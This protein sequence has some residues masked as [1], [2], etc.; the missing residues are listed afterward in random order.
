MPRDTRPG[1]RSK[2]SLLRLNRRWTAYP[3]DDENL[4]SL[5]T[6]AA[7]MTVSL[8]SFLYYCTTACWHLR[9]LRREWRM[10]VDASTAEHLLTFGLGN[11]DP[12]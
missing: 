8:N 5:L 1:P 7:G 6:T 2:F 10:K 3:T 12:T 4:N 9:L 11:V